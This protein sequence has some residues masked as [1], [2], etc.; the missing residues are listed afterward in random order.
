[1]AVKE[2]LGIIGLAAVVAI[3]Y[4]SC[5][6]DVSDSTE[7]RGSAQE[8][9][10]SIREELSKTQSRVGAAN[11]EIGRLRAREAQLVAEAARLRSDLAESRA[12]VRDAESVANYLRQ[13]ENLFAQIDQLRSRVADRDALRARL[14]D[15]ESA[16][17]AKTRRHHE[18][19][20]EFESRVKSIERQLSEFRQQASQVPVLQAGLEEARAKLQTT[21]RGRPDLAIEIANKFGTLLSEEGESLRVISMQLFSSRFAPG[22]DLYL[23]VPL[24]MLDHRGDIV[25]AFGSLRSR[26]NS[27]RID[28]DARTARIGFPDAADLRAAIRLSETPELGISFG[29]SGASTRILFEVGDSHTAIG[30][31]TIDFQPKAIYI[32]GE[33]MAELTEDGRWG[34]PR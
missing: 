13:R 20:T 32:A 31:T 27:F 8:S 19:V 24:G 1:M 11:E 10:E 3:A 15:A 12:M 2:T 9:L 23:T 5:S 33:R 4:S 28:L 18:V 22:Q 14:D 26:A 29:P 16:L 25:L 7:S 17:D 6:E 21:L 34:T 30:G